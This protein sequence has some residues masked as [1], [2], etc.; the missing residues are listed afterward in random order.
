VIEK[1]IPCFLKS[2]SYLNILRSIP[3]FLLTH[4]HNFEIIRQSIFIPLSGEFESNEAN[5]AKN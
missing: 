2:L 3:S 5:K 1:F 4:L